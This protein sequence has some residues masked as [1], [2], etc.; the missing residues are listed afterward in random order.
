MSSLIIV[1]GFQTKHIPFSGLH[2]SLPGKCWNRS[3]GWYPY[4]F[5]QTKPYFLFSG[6]TIAYLWE[7][8][9]VSLSL[10]Y[11]FFPNQTFHF[12]SSF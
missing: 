10:S 7:D 1:Q 2:F 3:I 9:K 5:F 6:C 4:N 11:L 8:V 12:C